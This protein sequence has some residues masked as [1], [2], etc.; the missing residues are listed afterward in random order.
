MLFADW[1]STAGSHQVLQSLNLQPVCDVV[2]TLPRVP[3][4]ERMDISTDL[5]PVVCGTV[6]EVREGNC[7]NTKLCVVINMCAIGVV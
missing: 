3:D 1:K 4:K 7:R 2:P 6:D 5:E